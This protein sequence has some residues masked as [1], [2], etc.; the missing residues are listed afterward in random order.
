MTPNQYRE[1][2]HLLDDHPELEELVT[3]DFDGA[4]FHLT[5]DALDGGEWRPIAEDLV[6]R[7]G[8]VSRTQTHSDWL[9]LEREGTGLGEMT[10]Y[11]PRYVDPAV[12]PETDLTGL[13]S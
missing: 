4:T 11:V 5:R 1:L 9:V 12:L 6:A 3:T 8:P 2:A 13:L 7:Y 10:F